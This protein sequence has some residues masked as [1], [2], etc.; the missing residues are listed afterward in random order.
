MY[1]EALTLR[2]AIGLSFY[3]DFDSLRRMLT[4][5]QA[6]PIDLIIAVDGKYKGH[7][8]DKEVSDLECRHLFRAF[9]TPYYLFHEA[10]AKTQIQQRQLYFDK[11]EVMDIDVIIVMDSDE[12][13]IHDKTN[14]PLFIKELE[15]HIEMNKGT[16]VQGYSIPLVIN[17]KPYKQKDYT[18]NSPRLF[19]RPSEL[20][21]VDNHYTIRN[22][23]TGV[24][25]AYQ[26]KETKLEHLVIGTDHKLRTEE[27]MQQHDAYEEYQQTDEETKENTQKRIDT[28]M[29][30]IQSSSL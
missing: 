12:Y 18:I 24:N 3:N 6:Y 20:Q 30:G 28:F 25:M 8:G 14:W 22:K 15:E 21:Y 10:T 27:Y 29:H 9:Q 4:S 1:G 16:F 13:I 26:T 19:H 2:L 23:K 5:L 11:A 7:T 17:Q